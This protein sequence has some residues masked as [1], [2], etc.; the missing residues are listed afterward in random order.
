[1]DSKSNGR[2]DFLKRAGLMG[3]MGS[4]GAMMAGAGLPESAMALGGYRGGVFEEALPMQ[5]QEAPKYHIKFGVCGMSHDHIYGMIGAV[6]RGG[7]EMVGAWGGEPDKLATF[8]KRFPDV[9][10]VKTQEEIIED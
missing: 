9:K 6:Q 2:R 8:A 3:A 10:M 4:V 5:E 1:M 7:G